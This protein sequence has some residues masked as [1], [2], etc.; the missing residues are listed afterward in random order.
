MKERRAGV[1]AKAGAAGARTTTPIDEKKEEESKK[2]VVVIEPKDKD[3]WTELLKAAGAKHWRSLK[4]VFRFRDKLLAGKPKSLKYAEAM[5][6]AKG[7]DDKLLVKEVTDPNEVAEQVKQASEAGLCEFHRREGRPGIW[8]PCNN[9]KAGLKENWSVLGLTYEKRGSKGAMAEGVFVYSDIRSHGGDLGE[10]DWV[11]LGAGPDG[12][13]EGVVHSTGPTGPRSSLKRNE[14]VVGREVTFYINI[15][16]DVYAKLDGDEGL[17]KTL[18]HFQ[19]HGLG[20][21]RSQGF[22]KFDLISVED[23]DN[24]L[25]DDLDLRTSN[26]ERDA[27]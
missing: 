25:E 9:I 10:L 5:V 18:I 11:Y 21:S 24:M 6:K 2:K 12:I 26:Q 3:Q 16:R 1:D 8:F 20:A 22:G 15:A 27:A 13:E 4:V 19:H 17:A 7:L 23:C 14:F